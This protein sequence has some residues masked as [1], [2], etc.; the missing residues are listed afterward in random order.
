[1]ENKTFIIKYEII[2]LDNSVIKDK[3]IKVKRCFNS[4]GAQCKLEDYLKKKY[5]SFN[6]LIVKS[7]EQDY[8]DNIF[9]GNI[10]DFGDIFGKMFG[11]G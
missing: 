11:G 4:I 5:S 9:G 2:L 6:K 7:C 3:E 1:M 10:D 8:M